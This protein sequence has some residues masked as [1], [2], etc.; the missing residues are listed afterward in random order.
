MVDYAV[1]C[2]PGT[3]LET[4]APEPILQ[5]RSIMSFYTVFVKSME[6]VSKG[7]LGT[8]GVLRAYY[9]FQEET[10]EVL[11]RFFGLP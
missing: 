2:T 5:R 6:P 4:T 11:F 7:S 1:K 3:L 9:E 8:Q 10:P